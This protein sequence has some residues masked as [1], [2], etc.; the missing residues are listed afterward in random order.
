[1]GTIRCSNP[2]AVQP[3]PDVTV[4]AGGQGVQLSMPVAGGNGARTYSWRQID[5]VGAGV[6]LANIN[7]D[8]LTVTTPVASVAETLSFELTVTDSTWSAKVSRASSCFLWRCRQ[9]G[10]RLL[11][12][13]GQPRLRQAAPQS[14]EQAQAWSAQLAQRGGREGKIIQLGDKKWSFIA[15]NVT[16]KEAASSRSRDL[17][18]GR[19]E[20]GGQTAECGAA[21]ASQ[22]QPSL[23][24]SSQLATYRGVRRYIGGQ[25]QRLRNAAASGGTGTYTYTWDYSAAPAGLAKPA[26]FTVAGHGNIHD[27]QGDGHYARELSSHGIDGKSTASKTLALT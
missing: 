27:T 22:Q 19:N 10:R 15:P 13:L 20:S 18:N 11:L 3:T 4:V 6:P 17:P 2:V 21:P 16:G 26:D 14:S 7:S 8:V 5:M 25:G 12:C 9:P 24:Q 23:S 1:M